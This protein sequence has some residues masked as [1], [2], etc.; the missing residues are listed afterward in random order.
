MKNCKSLASASK[1]KGFSL[2]TGFILVIVLFGALAFFLAGRGI[3]TAFG[4]TYANSTK[5]SNL[6]A[7]AAYMRTGVDSVIL[8]GTS[9]ASVSFDE[10]AT[11]GVFN[12]DTGAA[13]KQAVDPSVLASATP[14]TTEGYWVYGKNIFDMGGV[15]T[16]APDYTIMLLGLKTGV[17][18]QINNTLNGTALTVAPAALTED[19]ATLVGA[20][21]A[22]SPVTTLALTA[23]P[24]ANFT[25]TA[26]GKPS[27]CFTTSD[28]SNVFIHTVYPQ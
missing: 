9:P 21:T 4:T 2:L 3:N 20:P 23:A 22:A 16:I 17:C 10:V 6:I 28:G 15:G 14:A 12:L 7:S 1:Q 19:I 18:Q 11:T 13:T 24:A 8:S 26:N 27:G 5:V 25:I